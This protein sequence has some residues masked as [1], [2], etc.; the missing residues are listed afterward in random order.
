MGSNWF[1]HYR[2]EQQRHQEDIV[3]AE[4]E[5]LARLA[6]QAD[7]AVKRSSLL[8]RWLY[9]LGVILVSWGCRLQARSATEWVTR[10]Q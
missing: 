6:D 2:I 10:H 7:E 8:K 1:V 9:R 3:L 5:R 4:Q